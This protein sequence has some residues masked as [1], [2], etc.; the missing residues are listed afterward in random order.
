[1]IKEVYDNILKDISKLRKGDWLC[2]DD[3]LIK[4]RIKEERRPEYAA[5]IIKTLGDSIFTV[6]DEDML[7]NLLTFVKIKHLKKV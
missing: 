6:D 7:P 3:Y 2:L 5:V 4:Y 1:M